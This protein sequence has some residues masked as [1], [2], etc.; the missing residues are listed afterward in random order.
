METQPAFGFH[1]LLSHLLG[2]MAKAVSERNGET[3]QQQ[4]SRSQAAVHTIMGMLPRDAIEAMLAG[5]CLM[6]H[7]LMTD[8]VHDT[9]RGELGASRRATRSGIV[10]MDKAFVGNLQRLEHYQAR[11]ADGRRDVPNE[12]P[13]AAPLAQQ[14]E[15]P[16]TQA[17]APFQPSPES[18]VACLKNP[19]AMAALDARDP[20]AFAHAMGVDQPSEAYL[21]ASAGQMA[22]AN[23]RTLMNGVSHFA[24]QPAPFAGVTD[25]GRKPT[26]NG[27]AK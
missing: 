22:P 14:P 21:A 7:E 1:Q 5:H 6:L 11:P 2:D 10:A 26:S 20:K 19:A 23:R 15:P 3:K 17:A 9:L 18:L 24:A 8:A 16:K 27:R 12:Q 25:G 13:A 4:I